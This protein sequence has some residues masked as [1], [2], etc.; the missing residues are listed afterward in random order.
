MMGLNRQKIILGSVFLGLPLAWLTF[1]VVFPILLVVYLSFT[2]YDILGSPKWIGLLN[3]EDLL[4]DDVFWTA[5]LNTAYYTIVTVPVGMAL[6]LLLALF[7]NRRLPGVG[8]FRTVYYAPVVAP[9]VTTA[10]VWMLFYSET[11]GLF[12]YLLALLGFAPKQWLSSSTWAMPSVIVMSIWKG[13]GF[14][15]VIFLAGLQSI[16]RELYEAASLDGAGS[17]SSFRYITLPLL[18]P[19]T[20]YVTITSIIASFQVFSQ[21][22]VMTGGGPN[23]ST[24]TIVHQIYRTAF[25]HLEVGYASA[26]ALALFVILVAVSMV[27]LRLVARKEIYG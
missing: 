13:L 23:N 21:V 22:F 25:V 26:M 18:A 19:S 7:I 27:N 6:S 8:F 1:F 5:V 4:D 9:L 14:N 16:P 24:T 20:V 2:S 10:L 15:M 12:N 11:T 3:Y 17:T